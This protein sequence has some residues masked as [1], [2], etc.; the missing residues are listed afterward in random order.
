MSLRV[1]LSTLRRQRL[2]PALVLLQV[3]VACAILCNVLFLLWHQ[4]QPMVAPSGVD[5][6]GLI[7]IDQLSGDRVWTAPEVR[8]TE[9]MLR[10][11]PGVRA[12][13]A[14]DGLPMVTAEIYVLGLQGPSG[15]KAG[16]NAY[17]GEGLGQLLGVKLVAGRLFSPADY[18]DE[19]AK[20]GV[21]EPIVITRALARRLF[22]AASALGQLLHRPDALQG[23]GYQV[24]GVVD[25]LLRNQLGWAVDGKADNTVLLPERVGA[26]PSMSFAVRV[27]PDHQALA[28]REIGKAIAAHFADA[29]QAGMT[30]QVGS[31]ADRRDAAFRSRRAAAWLFFAVATT[32]LAVTV[33]GIM[34]LTGFWVQRRTRQ[35][36]IRRA[37]GA[38]RSQV[39]R[40]FML[41][42]ALIVGAGA[43]LGMALGYAGNL[44]L[45]RFYE[46]QRLPW[47]WLPVGA[48][49][50]LLVGQLSAIVPAREAARVPPV[51]ATRSV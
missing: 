33:I 39:L 2:L 41:E 51:V 1:M 24:V 17:V 48:V 8:A 26:T 3:A 19:G 32:V 43:L 38:R 10:A 28:M 9:A 50:M 40:E 12:A 36:G 5:E 4:L 49:A 31:F 21:P 18:R 37:L 11:V 46:L 20:W 45:M 6:R 30:P 16:V 23:P 34:G 44:W 47:E 14:A 25:H 35:I 15:A 29:M 22:G 42:N 13:T 27:D 7:L